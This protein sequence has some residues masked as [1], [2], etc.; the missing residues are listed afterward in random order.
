MADEID[1]ANDL[2]ANEISRALKEIRQ[3]SSEAVGT[4]FC[5]DCD[6]DMPIER[7]KLGFNRCV[8]CASDAERKKLM[9]ADE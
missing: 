1:L 7:Q 3:Q 2:I 4:K 9:Y 8:A 5:V 6:D